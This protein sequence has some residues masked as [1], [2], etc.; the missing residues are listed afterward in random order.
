M[1]TKDYSD[2]KTIQEIIE[3]CREQQDE[4]DSEINL[5]YL[6]KALEI[7]DKAIENTPEVDTNREKYIYERNRLYNRYPDLEKW[8]SGPENDYQ[9]DTKYKYLEWAYGSDDYFERVDRNIIIRYKNQERESG[10]QKF[11]E[12]H[13]EIFTDQ[14]YYAL[15]GFKGEV[16]Y[17][18]YGHQFYQ[19]NWLGIF[20]NTQEY[21]KWADDETFI[22]ENAPP[23][24]LQ[25]KLYLAV[26]PEFFENETK[27]NKNKNEE[28]QSCFLSFRNKLA[29]DETHAGFF[30]LSTQLLNKI[31]SLRKLLGTEVTNELDIRS[32]HFLVDNLYITNEVYENFIVDDGGYE[33]FN[34]DY[35][36]VDWFSIGKTKNDIKKELQDSQME[37]MKRL[38][39]DRERLLGMIDIER[40]G[41]INLRL[42]L[43]THK[44]YQYSDTEYVEIYPRS[45]YYF[46][47]LPISDFLAMF[48]DLEQ[49]EK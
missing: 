13:K 17:Q 31:S 34:Y 30:E 43:N 6:E 23:L 40:D 15:V 38:K 42:V 5:D 1:T 4:F 47:D 12:K 22:F 19:Q 37:E 3:Q 26:E 33:S 7:L 16:Y 29:E 25:K 20:L 48:P 2:P 18:D 27:I 45:Y 8:L 36:D 44:D 9:L 14:F 32:F 39:G 28:N 10:I 41:V 35:W 24:N 49:E 46:S 21:P 11:F